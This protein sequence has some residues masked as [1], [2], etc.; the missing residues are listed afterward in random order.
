MESRVGRETNA[1]AEYP[2]VL[3]VFP[4]ITF[5]AIGPVYSLFNVQG[6]PI[7]SFGEMFPGSA[8]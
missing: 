6:Q 7:K 2:Q 1:V 8:A 3:A 5:I 4:C